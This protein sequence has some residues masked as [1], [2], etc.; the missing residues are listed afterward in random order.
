VP[1]P[2]RSQRDR[3]ETTP[4]V[5][6]VARRSS[7]LRSSSAFRR[8]WLARTASNI[9]D[10]VAF[11]ALVLMV[12]N[13]ERT[14]FAVGAL[15][16]VQAVPRFFGPLAGAIA[17]RVEQRALMIGCDLANATIFAVIA[18]TTPS[19]PIL[20]VL[21]GASSCIDT[22]F[23][24]AGRSALPA[25]VARD[26]LLRANA[27]LAT[28]FN[29][30]LALGPMVG[31]AIVLALGPSGALGA[32][33]ASFLVSAL[34]LSGLPALRSAEEREGERGFVAT[35]LA[36]LRFA[37]QTPAV[38]G[39]VIALFFAVAFAAMDNVAL[40]F[41][42]R[43][44]LNGGALAF[45]LLSAAYGVGMVAASAA[46]ALRVLRVSTVGVF[47][48]GWLLSGAGIL[49][50]GLA[51]TLV[52]GGIGQVIAGSGN[53]G[54]NIGV[55]TLIQRI[56]PRPLLGR[57]FGVAFTAA[58]AGSTVAYGISGFLLDATSP[59]TVFLIGGSGVLAVVVLFVALLRERLG[60]D[61]AGIGT[62]ADSTP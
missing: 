20:L 12:H 35:G 23:A 55:E 54:A 9:G 47:L 5:D 32:N 27:L 61:A 21:A 28:S 18:I 10:G 1:E 51:P 7:L 44:T 45:G 38:R 6:G 25:L 2:P 4:V 15:L 22:L 42:V 16:L 58:F 36:G 41:L 33:T 37:W 31:G 49:L 50:T 40:V 57:T 17:D 11:V 60:E 13:R 19:L 39:I 52:L 3:F 56:V 48:L 26:D 46:L 53:G 59:R 8:L 34:I 24:P 29:L 14:G 30:Q 62:A 43:D